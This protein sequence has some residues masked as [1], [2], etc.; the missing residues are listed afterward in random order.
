MRVDVFYPTGYLK[1]SAAPVPV[2]QWIEQRSS[3]PLAASSN[4]A[5]DANCSEGK[6]CQTISRTVA[7]SCTNISILVYSRCKF[8][9]F[10]PAIFSGYSS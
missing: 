1:C 5:G 10:S 2:A 6:N 3:K 4:L 9:V 8:F 7:I